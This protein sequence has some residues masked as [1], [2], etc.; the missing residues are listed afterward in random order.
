MTHNS[1]T[2]NSLLVILFCRIVSYD[3]Y[4][5][6]SLSLKNVMFVE[7]LVLFLIGTQ[8]SFWWKPI[9][10]VELHSNQRNAGTGG[11]PGS[12]GYTGMTGMTGMSV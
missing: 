3:R 12:T 1:F 5:N 11:I 9:G 4:H 10:C 7:S 6:I 8:W 2:R